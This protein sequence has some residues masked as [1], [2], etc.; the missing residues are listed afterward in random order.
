MR[1]H[2]KRGIRA[3]LSFCMLLLAILV[4]CVGHAADHAPADTIQISH[5][6]ADPRG[7]RA[8]RLT[9][10]VNVPLDIYWRFK[11]NFNNPVLEDNP[12]ILSH[13]VVSQQDHV[14]ITEDHYRIMPDLFFRWRTTVFPEQHRLSYRLID[15]NQPGSR[16]HYGSIQVEAENDKTRIIH[17][18]YFDFWGASLWAVYPW[19]GGMWSF[20]RGSAEWEQRIVP[21]LR[22]QF[23]APPKQ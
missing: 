7:G 10:T 11:T 3:A 21:R 12:F 9:Y 23:E 13:R 14:V 8:Y 18:A 1:D 15:T 19:R 6:A 4:Y 5:P 22:H 17:T 2:G 20:L 16:F